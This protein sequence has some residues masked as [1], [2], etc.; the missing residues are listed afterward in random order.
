[1][2]M[3]LASDDDEVDRMEAKI[4]SAMNDQDTAP[5]EWSTPGDLARSGIESL[6]GGP[7][8]GEKSSR[9]YVYVASSWRN[10]GQ[11]AVVAAL[12][13]SGFEVYDFK[14]P[15]GGTSFAWEDVGLEHSNPR[16][17]TSETADLSDVGEFLSALQHHRSRAGF[18]SDF[19]AMRRAD[20]IV[21]VAPC[22]R[23]AHL[24]L[25]WGVGAGRRT[26]V[27]LDNPCTPELMYLMV[28]HLAPTIGSLLGWLEKTF[29]RHNAA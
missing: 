19:Q 16:D 6:I 7:V 13:D 2:K 4:L 21:A 28:D 12:R 20:A 26:A 9:G 22:G 23:S 27:L 1:M 14:N 8:R 3:S 29:P 25:G 24:E 18:A 10:A 15:P 11:P 17:G 5:A